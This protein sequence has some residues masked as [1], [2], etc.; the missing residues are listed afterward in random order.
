MKTSRL[1]IIILAV[2]LVVFLVYFLST[3]II[4]KQKEVKKMQNTVVVIETSKGNIELQ[5]FDQNAPITVKN[6]L[7]YVNGGF[8]KGTVFHR[9]MKGFMIQ[10]GGFTPDGKEKQTFAPIQLE[11]TDKTKLSNDVGTIAMARTNNPNSATSQFFINTVNNSFL[12]YQSTSNPGYAVFGIVTSGMDVVKKIED[13][14]T[15]TKFGSYANWPVDDVIIK[16]IYVK[17]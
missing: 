10:G 9:V 14:N 4:N 12:N 8:Y 7:K 3:N 17:K 16:D 1:I 6:F 5:L 2:I 15:T 13:V 11:S